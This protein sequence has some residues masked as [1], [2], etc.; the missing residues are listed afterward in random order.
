[1]ATFKTDWNSSDYVN[2]QDFNRIESN[3]NEIREKFVKHGYPIPT[4]TI[5]TNRISTSIDY[6]SDMN[7]IEQNV[8]MIRANTFTP[9]GYIEYL[10]WFY[11]T[12]YRS[13]ALSFSDLNRIET[14]LELLNNIADGIEANMK[15]PGMYTC[16]E[17]GI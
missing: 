8:D 11:K 5:K 3:T 15:Y 9:S 1:M 16:G 10:L 2:Y 13:S 6:L 4:L 12:W 17:G 7:R 14:N